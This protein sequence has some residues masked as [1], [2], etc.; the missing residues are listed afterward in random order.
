MG[1]QHATLVGQQEAFVPVPHKRLIVP[2]GQTSFWGADLGTT[3]LA[4]AMVLGSDR[5]VATIPFPKAEGAERLYTIYRET[6]NAVMWRIGMADWPEPGLVLT[7][8][9]SGS[10]QQVNLPF[11]MA[12][13]AINAGIYAGLHDLGLRPHFME[14][15]SGWWKKRATGTGRAFKP[16]K[17]RGKPRPAQT[18]YL[19]YKW[20]VEN[21]FNPRS[22]DE[23]DAA[24]M[25]VAGS[26]EFQLVER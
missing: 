15:T 1:F 12:A 23:A 19:V 2:T 10:N 13:G 21:G 16:K 3:K 5:R 4:L 20:A 6:R 7:E 11:I 18:D 14:V 25:A 8:Q 9:P 26:R 17:E 22:W 24:G